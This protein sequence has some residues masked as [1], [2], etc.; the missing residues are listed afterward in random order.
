MTNTA[1]I[2]I[3]AFF[4]VLLLPFR[5]IPNF[6]G[7]LFISLLSGLGMIVVFKHVSNQDKILRIRRRM[8]G[9]ILGILLH[10]SN[11]GTVM[12]FA[13]RLIWSNTVYLANIL[14]PI[15]VIAIPF[16]LLWGQLVASTGLPY[17]SSKAERYTSIPLTSRIKRTGLPSVITKR[18]NCTKRQILKLVRSYRE[19]RNIPKMV[20]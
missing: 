13:G 4:D 11:P 3:N 10:L 1:G 7:L 20:S 12:K 14:K 2:L 8:G 5:A 17:G 18:V 9:E 16:M 15:L 6:W 19:K